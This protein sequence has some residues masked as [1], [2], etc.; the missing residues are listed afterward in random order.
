MMTF[1]LNVM[2]YLYV[3]YL[4]YH[5]IKDVGGSKLFLG[6]VGRGTVRVSVPVSDACDTV[7]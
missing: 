4:G 6:G 5:S 7:L 1:D 3:F 2:T